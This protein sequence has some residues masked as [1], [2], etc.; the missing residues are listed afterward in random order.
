MKN[1]KILVVIPTTAGRLP[2]LKKVLTSVYSNTDYDIKTIVVKNGTFSDSEYNDFDF[3]IPNVIKTTSDVGGHIAMAMNVGLG[4]LTD[5]HW[6][7]YQEDDFVISTED[8]LNQ[9]INTYES[10]NNCGAL[11]V[12]LHGSQRNRVIKDFKIKDKDT[13]EVYWSD[14]ITLID[15]DIIRQHNLIYDPHMMTVPNADI[16]LQLLALKYENWRTEL[17]YTHH[18]TPGSKTGTPKWRYADTYVDMDVGDCQIYLK[19]NNSGNDKIQ[20]WVDSDTV[21]ATN[22]LI[23]NNRQNEDYKKFKTL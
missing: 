23:R 13:Y 21:R 3:E 22:W 10:I 9:I 6:F 15:A 12:R 14:G 19:Y 1:N 18:H 20:A 4:Y 7:L 2:L 8:W 17:T 16:N 5:E 11:G